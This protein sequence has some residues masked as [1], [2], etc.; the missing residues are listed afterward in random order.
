MTSGMSGEVQSVKRA[1]RLLRQ[2]TP[3]EPVWAVG[4]LSRATQ[5]HK[6]VVTRLMAT[7]ASEGFV[8]QRQSDRKYTIGP[9]AFAVGSLFEPFHMIHQVTRP[10]MDHLTERCGH[11][12]CVGV[13]AGDHFMIIDTF[14]GNSAIRVAFEIGERPYYHG[15]A[16]GKILLSSLP[17]AEVLDVVGP[18]P[19]AAITPQTIRT[20]AALQREIESVRANG[21]AVSREESITGVGAVAAPIVNQDKLTIA[22]ISIVYP[23]HVVETADIREMSALVREAAREGSRQL[24]LLPRLDYQIN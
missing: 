7:M 13:P 9:E 15:A 23:V 3:Q 19:L 5:L 22:S 11:S 16:I 6:S 10:V 14:E 2:F 20:H 1:L 12:T 21:F 8:V 4:E 24:H 18:E 17:W